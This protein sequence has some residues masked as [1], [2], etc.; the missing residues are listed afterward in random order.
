MSSWLALPRLASSWLALPW[1]ALLW[2]PLGCDRAAPAPSEGDVR[3]VSLTPAVTETLLAIGVR[4]QLVGVST[5][6]ELP[7][8]EPARPRLGTALTP[9][10]EAIVRA[11]PTHILSERHVGARSEGLARVAPLTELP[12][13]TLQDIAAST[14]TL[15]RIAGHPREA[16]A[17]AQRYERELAPAPEREGPRTLLVLG[18]PPT[19]TLS[20]VWFV[21]RGSIH[22]ALIDALGAR[23]AVLRDVAG[24]PRLS[25]DEVIR[26][27]PEVIVILVL[28]GPGAAQAARG[29]WE[30]LTPL[31]ALGAGRLHVLE[32][33]EAFSNG[34]SILE[35]KPKLRAL[36]SAPQ[37]PSGEQGD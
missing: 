19:P 25:V 20:E 18:G 14:R 22:G 8:G 12:W 23:H 32:A 7:T 13:L 15:G 24:V 1:L 4:E 33:R 26:I 5:Y 37:A 27:D 21:K 36:L 30:R 10:L 9:E 29:A 2:L 3:L 16:E 35:L 6:C 28:P 11:R 31:T 17:L 34:P